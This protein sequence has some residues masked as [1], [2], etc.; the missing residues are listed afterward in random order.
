[1]AINHWTPARQQQ[2]QQKTQLMTLEP[3]NLLIFHAF[4]Q[5]VAEQVR[6]FAKISKFQIFMFENYFRN[7]IFEKKMEFRKKNLLVT[8]SYAHLCSLM[9]FMIRLGWFFVGFFFNC[10]SGFLLALC[11]RYG[12]SIVGRFFF[13]NF[14]FGVL[15]SFL[16]FFGIRW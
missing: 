13:W 5:L 10:F 4:E 3:Q 15:W 11:A 14:F 7:L 16:E 6:H 1:M 9:F 8:S 2:Q 12:P